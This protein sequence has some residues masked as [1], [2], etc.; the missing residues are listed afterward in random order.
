MT[1]EEMRSRLYKVNKELEELQLEGID[2]VLV[3][4]GDV[5]DAMAGRTSFIQVVKGRLHL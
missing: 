4:K 5:R 1:I 3:Q 2:I